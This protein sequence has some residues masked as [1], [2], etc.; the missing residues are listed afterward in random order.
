VPFRGTFEHSLD[1]KHRLTIPAAFR[2]QLGTEVVLAP[3][4]RVRPDDPRALSI[5][6]PEVYDEFVRRSLAGLNPMSPEAIDLVR[7]LSGDAHDTEL[8]SANRVMIPGR[9]LTLCG[10][11]K[12]VAVCGSGDR[13][14]VWDR[15]THALTM[16]RIRDRLPETV[17]RVVNTA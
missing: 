15:D 11:E 6:K 8:D 5:W 7:L 10:L 14:E 12:D 9:L 3:A 16:E 13:I 4:P 2:R 1:A 17:A